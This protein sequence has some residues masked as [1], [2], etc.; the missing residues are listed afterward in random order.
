MYFKLAYPVVFLDSGKNL[1]CSKVSPVRK[2]II[3]FGSFF[4]HLMGKNIY[5]SSEM[6]LKSF[7]SIHFTGH[8]LGSINSIHLLPGLLSILL[9]YSPIWSSAVTRVTYWDFFFFFFKCLIMAVFKLYNTMS[10]HQIIS[11]ILRHTRYNLPSF[12]VSFP[13]SPFYPMV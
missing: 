11:E 6:P 7:S 8:Y 5:A 1:T 10:H 13:F 12:S 4:P 2:G 9:Q 3:F